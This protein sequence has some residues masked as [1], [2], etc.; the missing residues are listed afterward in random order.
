MAFVPVQQRAEVLDV[1]RG[2]AI[3]GKIDANGGR[4]RKLAALTRIFHQ[5][6]PN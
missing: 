3:F 6:G 4:C 2:I 1:L 5:G